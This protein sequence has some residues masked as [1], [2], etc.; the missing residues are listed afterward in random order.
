[1]KC[2]DVKSLGMLY[3]GASLP[4]SQ[5]LLLW[6]FLHLCLGVQIALF[7]LALEGLGALK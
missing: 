1:M 5:E 2:V 6:Y 3:R 7:Q 4:S